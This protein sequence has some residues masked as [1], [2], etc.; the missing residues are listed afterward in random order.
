MS[1]RE[2]YVKQL[3]PLLTNSGSYRALEQKIIADSNLPGPRGNLE[4]SYA[5]GDCFEGVDVSNEQWA[6]LSSWTSIPASEASTNDPKVFLPVC[7]LQALGA[8]YQKADIAR[9]ERIINI[10][11]VAAN[12]ERW[13]VRE[14]VAMSF[15]RVGEKDS[16]IIES[17]FKDWIEQASLAE[18][19]AIIASLAHP[20]ILTDKDFVLF[21]LQ[22]VEDI[23]SSFQALEPKER[24]TEDFTV[25]K[26]GLD[27]SI[28]V[29]VAA[30]P[31]EGFIFLKEWAK[32]ADPAIKKIIKSNL[33][34]SR[35]TKKYSDQVNEILAL[36]E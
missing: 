32:A 1:K 6:L 22:M 3:Q 13:R 33:G 19:R 30:L 2:D 31:E 29:F 16:R 21:C 20:P 5:F 35:L 11:K 14:A 36:L 8:I 9:K 34:K 4:L 28:S 23:L 10:L 12:D 26:K 7:A 25:L 17:I 27:Y 18:K 15:Q 24:K